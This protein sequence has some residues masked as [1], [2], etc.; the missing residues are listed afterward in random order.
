MSYHVTFFYVGLR[1]AS[2]SRRW[3]LRSNSNWMILTQKNLVKW[4]I[5]LTFGLDELVHV[6]LKG[7]FDSRQDLVGLSPLSSSWWGSKPGVQLNNNNR[8]GG[9]GGAQPV[10]RN[11]AV[12]EVGREPD[13]MEGAGMK[14]RQEHVYECPICQETATADDTGKIG[15]PP[16]LNYC[17]SHF[18]HVAHEE[19]MRS[20][21]YSG[22]RGGRHCP[23]CRGDLRFRVSAL[24]LN[25][26]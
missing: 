19:C 22:M 20:W 17:E 1:F 2:V 25:T 11:S 26:F 9:G 3:K 10:I 4:I 13:E 8:E 5:F 15:T 18:A 16:L 21:F 7:S 24:P 12:E 6:I 23:I 14:V